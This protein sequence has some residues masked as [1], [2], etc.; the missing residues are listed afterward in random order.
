MRG[1]N[2]H[3]CLDRHSEGSGGTRLWL[4]GPLADKLLMTRTVGL[5][6]SRGCA[7]TPETRR[8]GSSCGG[9]SSNLAI[10]ACACHGHVGHVGRVGGHTRA[11]T[12][13]GSRVSKAMILTDIPWW[14]DKRGGRDTVGLLDHGV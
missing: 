5:F 12:R 3:G 2:G 9:T 4:M 13:G 11:A 8:S 1:W 14:R 6:L 10:T 7:C